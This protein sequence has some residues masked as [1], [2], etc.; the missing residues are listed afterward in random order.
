MMITAEHI[1]KNEH[2]GLFSTKKWK[3][4]T[5]FKGMVISSLIN[6]FKYRIY[7]Y[8]ILNRAGLD[9]NITLSKFY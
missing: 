9:R 3:R 6:A 8:D 2:F 7:I 1:F 4:E 5:I